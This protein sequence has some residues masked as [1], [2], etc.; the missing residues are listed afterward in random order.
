MP[1]GGAWSN[2]NKT[3]MLS[4]VSTV[5]NQGGGAKKAGLPYQIG[6]ES[7]TSRFFHSTDPING[8]CCNLKKIGTTMVFTKNT[9]RPIGND[10]RIQMR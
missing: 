6:R 9:I 8:R 1:K 10:A 5:K 2:S 3:Q 7:W 4:N